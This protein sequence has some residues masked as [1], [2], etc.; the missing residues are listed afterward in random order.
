MQGQA[1]VAARLFDGR[2]L[3]GATAVLVAGGTIVDLVAPDAVPA[4]YGV[5]RLADDLLLSPGFIDVQVNGGGGV[6][7]NDQ[8]SAEGMRAIAAAH[9]PFGTTQCLPTLITDRPEVMR[10][11]AAAAKAAQG[12]DGVL[13]LHLEGPYLNPARH[14][15]H[16]PAFMASP[17]DTMLDL[18]AGAA[19][20]TLAP[21]RAPPGF[22]R[23]LV[24]R[25]VRVAAGHSEAS[26]AQLLAAVDEGLSGITH[27]FNAMSQM[28]GRAPGMVG[29][30]LADPRLYAGIIVDGLHVDPVS[31]RAAYNAKGPERLMLV[32]D[33]MPTVGGD[34]ERFDLLGATVRLVDGRLITADG[35]LAGAHLD[36]ASAVRNAVRLTHIPLADALAMATSTPAAFL[37]RDDRLG[38]LAGDCA[39]DMVAL[40]GQLRVKR[41]WRAGNET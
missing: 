17:D 32:T 25:G 40:D 38:R 13:G 16:R 27:L 29:A 9:L 2:A 34:V 28:Q 1:I 41:V 22:I 37:G 30:T 4:G 11:A 20:V 15:V 19:L 24:Q 6:L 23:A 35:T 36:M 31:V 33:A 8:P 14:G 12:R 21:E 39:A 7:L 10:Q 3:R 18:L 26:A 5:V